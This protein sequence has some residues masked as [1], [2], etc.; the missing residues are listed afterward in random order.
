MIRYC[1]LVAFCMGVSVTS[2]PVKAAEL[3]TL[4]VEAASGNTAYESGGDCAV[5]HS[6]ASTFKVP[7]AL[8]GFDAG[9]LVDPENPVVPHRTEY[10]APFPSWRT[11]VT[12]QHWLRHSVVWYSQVLTRRLG[13]DSFQTYVDLFD[14]GNRDLSGD[15]GADNGLTHA[16]LSSSL[17]IAPAEQVEFFRRLYLGEHSVSAAAHEMTVASMP[18]FTVEPGW[19]VRAKTGTA[20]ILDSLGNRTRGQIGWFAGWIE[21]ETRAFIFVRLTSEANPPTGFASSRTKRSFLADV[22]SLIES[23]PQFR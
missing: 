7:L 20:Y 17:K 15:P 22:S 5:P 1:L 3:C 12:P 14:Y 6:P 16:W 21:D 8:M 13:M 9:Y 11:S 19:M 4:I 23:L 2:L 18:V 10:K